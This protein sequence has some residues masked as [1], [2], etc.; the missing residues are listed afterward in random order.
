MVD[1]SNYEK[2]Q[3]KIFNAILDF[4]R[5]KTT[6]DLMQQH[7]KIATIH[8]HLKEMLDYGEIKVY[9]E[10]KKGRKKINY[11]PTFI[12]I[13]QF[14]NLD[15]K[16]R[17]NVEQIYVDWKDDEK[18]KEDLKENGFTQELLD[19]PNI[20]KSV[21]KDL[22][23]YNAGLDQSFEK[24]ANDPYSIPEVIR[25]FIGGLLLADKKEYEKARLN[26]I[27]HLPTYQKI[28]EEFQKIVNNN[29]YEKLESEVKKMKAD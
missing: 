9:E 18:F 17:K 16:I 26:I 2:M 4:G 5:P 1:I 7:L 23:F 15:N 14:Y 11:G 25:G 10:T 19:D 27:S 22:I 13:T 8:R 24:L 21:F 3:I 28:V 12:G 29:N 6:Y 20:G